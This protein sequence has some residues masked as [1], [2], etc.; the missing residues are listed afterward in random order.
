MKY[1]GAVMENT[2][3]W[4]IDLCSPNWAF[5]VDF[6]GFLI[7]KTLSDHQNIKSLPAVIK[8]D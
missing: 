6:V 4:Q 3:M 8:K 5:S 2:S 7:T 1:N